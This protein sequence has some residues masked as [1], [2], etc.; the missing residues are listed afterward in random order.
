M[1]L[2]LTYFIYYKTYN[3]TLYI[4]DNVGHNYLNTV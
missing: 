4:P 3:L 2:L 1:L